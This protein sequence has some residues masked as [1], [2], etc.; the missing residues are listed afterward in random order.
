M[1][2]LKN[3]LILLTIAT[4]GISTSQAQTKQEKKTA[5][6]AA[7]KSQIDAK[8]YTFIANYVLPQRGSGRALT[9]EYDL[10]VTKDTVIA[11]LPYFG[12]AYFGVP[13]GGGGDDA[14]IKFTSTKFAYKAVEKKKGG[15]EIT[16]TPTD[17]KYTNQLQLY[18][19]PDGYTSLTVRSTNRDFIT[20]DGYLKD[21]PKK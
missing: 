20:F 15:W 10:K 11:Y 14:G 18:I 16:I 7:V 9:S 3:M 17:A 21:A 6:E 8:N 1:K 5:K 12:R 2:N 19:S 13:Y 4:A